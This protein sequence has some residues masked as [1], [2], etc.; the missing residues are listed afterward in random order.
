MAGTGGGGLLLEGGGAVTEVVV[1]GGGEDTVA[2]TGL[3]AGEVVVGAL[4]Q[5][6]AA[7]SKAI[8]ASIPMIT[9]KV[10]VGLSIFAFSFFL[11]FI[12]PWFEYAG[13]WLK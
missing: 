8:T 6:L 5:P 4:A 10:L 11:I 9:H 3:L 7:T 1:G 12:D 2:G 13:V